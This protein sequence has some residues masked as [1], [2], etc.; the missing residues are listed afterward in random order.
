MASGRDV[1]WTDMPAVEI[2]FRETNLK[3]RQALPVTADM[4]DIEQLSKFDGTPHYL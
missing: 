2:Y 3:V 1:T 4:T